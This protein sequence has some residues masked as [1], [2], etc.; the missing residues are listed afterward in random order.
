MSSE[1]SLSILLVDD[2]EATRQSVGDH[3]R[4]RQYVIR[5]ATSGLEALDILHSDPGIRV[6]ITDWMMPDLNGIELCRLARQLSRATYLY[7][8]VLTSKEEEG[9][10]R[11]ALDAGADAFIPKHFGLARLDSQLKVVHRGVHMEQQQQASA[12]AL[13]QA[14]DRLLES[15]RQLS[16]MK[17]RYQTLF[18][19]FSQ[20]VAIFSAQGCYQE[21]NA[22][23][24]TLWSQPSSTLKFWECFPDARAA[25]ARACEGEETLIEPFEYQTGSGSTVTIEIQLKPLYEGGL[26][27]AV[28]VSVEDITQAVVATGEHNRVLSEARE[29]LEKSNRALQER[30]MFFSVLAHEMRNPVSGILGIVDLLKDPESV[31]PDLLGQLESCATS[32]TG[33]ID[34]TLDLERMGQGRLRLEEKP[35]DLDNTIKS[36]FEMHRHLAGSRGLELSLDLEEVGY[37][38]GDEL[39]TRQILTNLLSNAIKYTNCGS[40]TVAGFVEDG[41]ASYR[42]QV[43]DTGVGISQHD[44]ET[45]F[46]AYFQTSREAK[47]SVK[48]V[49][50]G[51]SIVKSL[52]DLM[53]GT[54]GVTS[55]LGKGSTFWAAWPLKRADVPTLQAEKLG[56]L[57]GRILVVDDNSINRRILELQLKGRGAMVCLAENGQEAL[58][59]LEEQPFDIVLMDCQMP[60]MDGYEASRA[61]RANPEIYHDPVIIALSASASSDA[62]ERCLAAGMTE[63]LCKPIRHLDLHAKLLAHLEAK[64]AGADGLA[65]SIGR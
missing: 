16:E 64:K 31:S 15:N 60:I 19:S 7:L 45:I 50:L 36:V 62:R 44:L 29:D 55:T 8:L 23:A 21:G 63:F 18:H 49:G 40:V 26:V 47:S 52:V 5:T 13:K 56:R 41:G 3:L 42:F 34:D 1:A 32:L 22:L 6:V 35:F 9:D 12:L 59:A 33:L 25:F 48:G 20:A 65:P 54:L 38:S 61:I 57:S 11:V 37:V 24:E 14:N 58:R 43:T 2:H 53:Q 17:T 4:G 39:R 46:D 51:L 30:E 10:L 28:V 27:D